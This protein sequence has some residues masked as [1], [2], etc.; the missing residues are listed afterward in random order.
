[1]KEDK[2]HETLSK[3]IRWRIKDGGQRLRA[4][5]SRCWCSL[6]WRNISASGCVWDNWNTILCFAY[7]ATSVPGAHKKAVNN[8]T[9]DLGPRDS[10]FGHEDLNVE[11]FFCQ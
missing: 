1:M 2:Y 3:L 6:R 5:P 10:T 11:S 8:F 9:I 4:Y 7:G